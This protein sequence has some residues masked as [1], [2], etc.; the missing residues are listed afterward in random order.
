[1]QHPLGEVLGWR[2]RAGAHSSANSGEAWCS[3]FTRHFHAGSATCSA[4]AARYRPAI[5]RAGLVPVDEAAARRRVG[6]HQP[7]GVALLEGQRVEV[8][9]DRHVGPV[10][11]EEVV[12]RR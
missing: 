3:R 10:V 1:M 5:M 12:A 6:E 8:A 9:D 7:Q 4:I 11:G 2:R